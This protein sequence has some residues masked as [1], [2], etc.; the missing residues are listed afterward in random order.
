MENDLNAIR[1]EDEN[2]LK[3]TYFEMHKFYVET[4]VSHDT[5]LSY[6]LPFM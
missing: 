3:E 5:F 4:Y 2:D 6:V 1:F